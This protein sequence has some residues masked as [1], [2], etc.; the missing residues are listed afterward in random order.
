MIPDERIKALR[1]KGLASQQAEID[2]AREERKAEL[3]PEEYGDDALAAIAEEM[4]AE[5]QHLL[6]MAGM[7]RQELIHRLQERG[8]THLETDNWS[9]VLV[10]TGYNHEINT[11]ALLPLEALVPPEVWERAYVQPPLPPRRWNQRVLNELVKLGGDVR[12]IIE[13][14]RA[15]VPGEPKL[16]LKRKEE[17][18]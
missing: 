18:E 3:L 2:Q 5:G 15:S 11:G 14:A 12:A 6:R 7:A 1:Q 16:D 13:D 17:R 10:P 9:G 4:A 8:A